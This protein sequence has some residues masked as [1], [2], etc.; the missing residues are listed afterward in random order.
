[1]ARFLEH[2]FVQELLSL[3]MPGDHF[4]IAG[5]G[6]LY[7]RGRIDAINDLDVVARGP[8]WEIAAAIGVSKP[9]PY[10]AVRHISLFQGHVEILDGWFP[11]YWKLDDLIDGA[12]VMYGIRFVRLEVV[13]RTKQLL[14]RPRDLD[15]L[16][17]LL[18]EIPGLE[19]PGEAEEPT[20]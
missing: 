1:M 17:R 6:P 7:V 15:H 5:S 11:E 20:P 16:Q 14:G 9:A 2:A 19:S 4:A 3:E 10:S 13:L 8:A 12:D 18:R